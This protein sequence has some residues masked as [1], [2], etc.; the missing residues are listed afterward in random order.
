[1]QMTRG[2]FN[3]PMTSPQAFQVEA[4]LKSLPR[5]SFHTLRR[6]S[7][8][9]TVVEQGK[10]SDISWIS[11]E[12]IDREGD[13]VLAGGM[14]DTQFAANPVVTWN[15]EYEIPPVGLS[16][17]RKP[18]REGKHRGIRAK[19]IYP[20]KPASFPE[21]LEWMPETVFAMVASG[22]VAGKSIG[23]V[24]LVAREPTPAEIREN[25]ALQNARSIIERWLLLE[26]ACCSFPMQPNAL[27]EEVT[28]A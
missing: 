27:V 19:T 8:A 24:P 3:L 15:H 2:P 16:A 17:W 12:S 4:I 6:R 9:G 22:L 10:R 14:D 23:F 5:D 18:A 26:Y 7:F 11:E 1:M 28:T 13:V 25:P 21:R 20:E